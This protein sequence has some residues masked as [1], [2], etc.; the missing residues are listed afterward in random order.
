MAL[1]QLTAPCSENADISNFGRKYAGATTAAHSL[2]AFVGKTPWTNIDIAAPDLSGPPFPPQQLKFAL[3]RGK[4]KHGLIYIIHSTRV[5][6]MRVSRSSSQRLP[7]WRFTWL[8]CSAQLQR[9]SP[10]EST[11]AGVR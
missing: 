6:H 8:A 5:Y 9:R 1:S 7:D 4:G 2:N 11:L 10:R 3:R